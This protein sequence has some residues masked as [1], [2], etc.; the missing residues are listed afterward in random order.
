MNIVIQ[1]MG[2]LIA[3]IF[4]MPFIIWMIFSSFKWWFQYGHEKEQNVTLMN[5][6]DNMEML[7]DEYNQFVEKYNNKQSKLKKKLWN[8]GLHIETDDEGNELL[9]KTIQMKRS[10]GKF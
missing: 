3:G 9:V 2:S 5:H 7:I 4:V 6:D 8:H 1:C 10:I